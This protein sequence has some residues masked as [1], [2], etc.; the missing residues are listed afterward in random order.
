MLGR[1]QDIQAIIHLI[2]LYGFAV[3]TQR[4][5]LFDRIFTADVEADF[6]DSAGRVRYLDAIDP[7]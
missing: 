6:S 3:D 7:A 5:S 2:N 1:M 4:W